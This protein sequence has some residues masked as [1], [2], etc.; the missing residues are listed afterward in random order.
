MVPWVKDLAR[1]QLKCRLQ[2]QLGFDFWSRNFHRLGVRP[3]KKKK[4]RN[5]F[6]LVLDAQSSR[7]RS[8]SGEISLACRWSLSPPVLPVLLVH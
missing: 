5:V 4:I 2:L 3:K 1:L 8:V 7:S 6:F